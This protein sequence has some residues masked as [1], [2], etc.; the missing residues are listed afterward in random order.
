[1]RFCSKCDNQIAQERYD[2]GF[3]ECLDCST[4]E[5]KKALDVIFHKTGNCL[6]HLDAKEYNDVAKRFL[7]GGFRSNLGQIKGA[8][9][10]EFSRKIE[11]GCSL[12][13]V[14]SEAMF[15]KV[16]EEAMFKLD[17]LGLDKALAYL[18]RCYTDVKI[19][20]GELV[21]LK[22]VIVNFHQL[23]QQA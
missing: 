8:G 20:A 1:M 11:V 14:G 21:K 15:N 2:L 9:Y 3:R 22:N 7:R 18:D 23:Q 17:I 19:T 16:G 13:K 12:A 4:V 5:K 6:Q 10:K